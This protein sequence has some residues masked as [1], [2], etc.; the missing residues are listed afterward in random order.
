M[1]SGL[2]YIQSQ[3]VENVGR[4]TVHVDAD[5][6]LLDDES[7]VGELDGII[8]DPGTRQVRYFVIDADGPRYLLPLC[9]TRLD[10]TENSLHMMA[11]DESEECKTFYP[12]DYPEFEDEDVVEFMFA[13]ARH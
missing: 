12:V 11:P 6:E 4:L 2:R 10:H 5:H 1:E 8:V 9:S 3:N 7:R 13:Q